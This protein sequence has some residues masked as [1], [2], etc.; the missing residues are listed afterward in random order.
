MVVKVP[1][2]GSQATQWPKPK[3]VDVRRIELGVIAVA[4]RPAHR[5]TDQRVPARDVGAGDTA[6]VAPLLEAAMASI[7]ATS[8]SSAVKLG[9]A[10]G[11]G[12]HPRCGRTR[13]SYGGGGP[14]A[15]DR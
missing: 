8:A 7:S 3:S 6:T 4:E 1:P 2:V 12:R 10:K 15:A 5:A 9:M 14:P 13:S 11:R